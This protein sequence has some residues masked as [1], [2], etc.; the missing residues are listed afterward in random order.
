MII[1]ETCTVIS[2]ALMAFVYVL[3]ASKLSLTCPNLWIDFTNYFPNTFSNLFV[4]R[5][6]LAKKY[7]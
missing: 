3:L 7:I 5:D 2:I 1:S 6:E 4:W